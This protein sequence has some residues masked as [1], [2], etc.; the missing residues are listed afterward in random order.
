M[1]GHVIH[2][3]LPGIS[4]QPN[5]NNF[6][7][8]AGANTAAFARHRETGGRPQSQHSC[9]SG[10]LRIFGHRIAGAMPAWF[11]WSGSPSTGLRQTRKNRHPICS[12]NS[13]H[14]R[15]GIL[16]AIGFQNFSWI[17]PATKIDE[18]KTLTAVLELVSGSMH[19][20]S[21]RARSLAGGMEKGPM[22]FLTIRARV[23]QKAGSPPDRGGFR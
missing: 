5:C 6:V 13:S 4:Q 10:A 2:R 20:S 7:T 22:D 8:F 9:G 1:V 14:V 11:L 23:V 15:G 17:Q 3:H 12:P 19:A 16:P 21:A 18:L